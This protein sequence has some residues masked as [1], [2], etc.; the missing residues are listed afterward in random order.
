MAESASKISHF[1]YLTAV[2]A[3]LTGIIFFDEM[4]SWISI[5]GMMIII[6]SVIMSSRYAAIK[7]KAD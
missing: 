1:N 6:G 2:W 4:L 7:V 5:A 3:L